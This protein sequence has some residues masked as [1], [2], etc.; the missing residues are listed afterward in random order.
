MENFPLRSVCL[1]QRRSEHLV[2]L[3][4]PL[5]V[6][7]VSYPVLKVLAAV[8]QDVLELDDAVGHEVVVANGRVVEN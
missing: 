8:L 1:R 6:L 4:L 2:R 7:Q 5:C 3:S